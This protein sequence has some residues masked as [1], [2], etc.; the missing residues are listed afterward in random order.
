M[1]I[2][3]E[4]I[5]EKTSHLAPDEVIRQ[6]RQ[7]SEPSWDRFRYLKSG[8]TFAGQVLENRFKLIR[9][10][11]IRLKNRPL[12]SGKVSATDFGSKIIIKVGYKKNQSLFFLSVF[13]VFIFFAMSSLIP[14]QLVAASVTLLVSIGIMGLLR[15]DFE[16]ECHEI[17]EAFDKSL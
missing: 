14:N 4:H 1:K 15:L 10:D 13:F 17:E 7:R 9:I 3:P 11:P 16:R 8:K 12:I 6:I 2:L 5:I